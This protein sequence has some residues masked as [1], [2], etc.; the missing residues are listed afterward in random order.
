MEQDDER[1][2]PQSDGRAKNAIRGKKS[3]GREIATHITK[4]PNSKCTYCGLGLLVRKKFK[5]DI[6][7][8]GGGDFS[9]LGEF[10]LHCKGLFYQHK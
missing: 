8:W 7:Y 1:T 6:R 4:N 2:P 10:I 5:T 9:Y 3:G